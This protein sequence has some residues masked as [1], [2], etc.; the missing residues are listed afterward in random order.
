MTIRILGSSTSEVW[1]VIQGIRLIIA[2]NLPVDLVSISVVFT[3]RPVIELGSYWGIEWGTSI[4]PATY[5][6]IRVIYSP[7]YR[8]KKNY[9]Y[10][11]ILQSIPMKAAPG[12]CVGNTGTST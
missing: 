10:V 8:S 1:R 5:C 6:I 3:A 11:L 9:I 4:R 12:G 7:S 2:V